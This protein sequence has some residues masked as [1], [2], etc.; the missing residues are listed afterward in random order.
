MTPEVDVPLSRFTTIG[1]GGPAHA[2][3]RPKTLVE[4]EQALQFAAER[5]LPARAVGLGSNLLAADI[6]VDVVLRLMDAVSAPA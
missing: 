6:G 4:L 1:T 3:A 2:F 5:D